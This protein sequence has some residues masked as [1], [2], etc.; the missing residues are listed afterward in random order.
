MATVLEL[1]TRQS[2]D[3]FEEIFSA[4]PKK[5][6]EEI[7]R[8]A[9]VKKSSNSFSL[10]SRNKNE[11]R[12]RKL[13]EALQDGFT[14]QEEVVAEV[15]RNY[16]YTRRD[17]LASALDHFGVEHNQGLTD[18][19]LDFIAELSTAQINNFRDDLSAQSH[20]QSD[21]ELYLSFMGVTD[22]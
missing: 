2:L 13:F 20:E 15:V 12:N 16:L 4:S 9:G 6:R 22:K 18:E 10:K 7:Y 5:F 8:Q 19:D 21:V 1:V 3:R 14:I 17:L 11:V